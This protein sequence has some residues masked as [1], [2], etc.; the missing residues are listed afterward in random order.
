MGTSY[1]ET[2]QWQ[3]VLVVDV[4]VNDGHPEYDTD[5]Y[6]GCGDGSLP[7]IDLEDAKCAVDEYLTAGVGE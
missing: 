1:Q 6:N 7:L 2:L 3:E 4:I 5:G